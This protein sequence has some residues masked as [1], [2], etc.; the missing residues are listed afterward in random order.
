MEKDPVCGM[1]VDPKRSAGT[2]SMGGKTYYFCSVGCKA[3]FDRNPA[4]FAK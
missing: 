3:T 1:M 4:K 2:S